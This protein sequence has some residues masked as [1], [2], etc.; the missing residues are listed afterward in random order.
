MLLDASGLDDRACW[1]EA[2]RLVR[3]SRARIAYLA[4]QLLAKGVVITD[5]SLRRDRSCE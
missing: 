1:N 3:F 5:Q 4:L 2:C